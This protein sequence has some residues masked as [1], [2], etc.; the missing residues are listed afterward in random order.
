MSPERVVERKERPSDFRPELEII[1][2]CMFSGKTDEMIRRLRRAVIAGQKVQVFKHFIDKRYDENSLGSHAGTSFDAV[3]VKSSA[4]I[5]EL[6]EPDT[7]V[8]AV[9]EGQFF[10][11]ELPDVCQKLVDEYDVR[12][13]VAGLD[14]DFRHEPFGVIPTLMAQAEESVKLK[15]ICMVCGGPATR[16]QRFI[17]GKPAHYNDPVIVVGAAEMY[18][19]RCRE[20][21]EVPRD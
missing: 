7:T 8:V 11:D 2:G 12:V 1:V 9:D 17:D 21:H 4:E 14:T 3:P 5:L 16:T 20:H 15:A 18:E 10:D 6:I 13:I 19:A